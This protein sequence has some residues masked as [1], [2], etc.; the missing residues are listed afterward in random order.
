MTRRMTGHFVTRWAFD[1]AEVPLSGISVPELDWLMANLVEAAQDRHATLAASDATLE[2]IARRRP[3]AAV[4]P[5]AA[6]IET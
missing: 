1:I 6:I 4:D 3:S 2:P 5:I